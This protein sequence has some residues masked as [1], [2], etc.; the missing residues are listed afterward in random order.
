VKTAQRQKKPTDRTII[1]FAVVQLVGNT[2]MMALDL[3]L[4]I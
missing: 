2:I 3:P 1:S 4:L